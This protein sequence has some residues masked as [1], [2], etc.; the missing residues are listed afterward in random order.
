MK[1]FSVTIIDENNLL[2]FE[3][4]CRATHADQDLII[5]LIEYR[6]IQP[7]GASKENWQFDH[8][9]LK[10][11]RLARNFYYDCEVNLA[12]I[13]MLIDMLEKIDTLETQISR[14]K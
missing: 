7:K 5:Q 4:I 8:V 1:N 10:R 6:V 13:G 2:T 12:G 11:A 14:L 9:N 3:E